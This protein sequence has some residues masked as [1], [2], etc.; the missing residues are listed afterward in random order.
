MLMNSAYLHL[1]THIN[2]STF[3]R[4]HLC[5]SYFSSTLN[6]FYISSFVADTTFLLLNLLI[7]IVELIKKYACTLDKSNVK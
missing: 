5:V 3:L 1:S 4:S 6:L 2:S 7:L